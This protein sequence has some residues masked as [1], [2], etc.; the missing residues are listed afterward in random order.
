MAEDM[1]APAGGTLT[2]GEFLEPSTKGLDRILVTGVPDFTVIN[3]EPKL[4]NT[5]NRAS[6]PPASDQASLL[7]DPSPSI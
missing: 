5:A 1:A 4:E 7:T 6:N 3:E 2:A